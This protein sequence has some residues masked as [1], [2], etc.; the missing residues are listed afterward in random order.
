MITWPNSLIREIANR[1]VVFFLGSGVSASS[2]ND[3]GDRPKVW[4]EFLLSAADLVADEGSRGEILRLIQD[5]NYLLA[6]QAIS[7]CANPA[8]YRDFLNENFN[9][10]G[11][12][13]SRLHEI[14]L[15]LD[16]NIVITTN[17]DKIYDRYCEATSRE[18]YK[19][20]TYDS[21]GLGDLIRSDDRVI[22]KAHGCINDIGK[23]VF[24][25]SQYHKA[26]ENHPSFYELLKAIF[27]THTCIFIGCG[28]D[29]PDVLLT[30]ED[31]KITSSGDLPHYTLILGGAFSR[32]AITDWKEAYNIQTLEY[33][34]SHS[35]LVT[36]LEDLLQEVNSYRATHVG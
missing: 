29:D 8:D 23:M 2:T 14:I 22:M 10:P 31:V 27:L 26:K 1:R 25:K 3:N 30:L 6:L 11:F 28:L 24:T 36:D 17:F 16:A 35:A 20:V 12:R 18:G 33:E 4:N 7:D 13:P 15:E 32:F 9:N 21:K 19:I 5:R 34:G